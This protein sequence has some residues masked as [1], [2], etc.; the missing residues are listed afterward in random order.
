MTVCQ[1]DSVTKICNHL[2][3]FSEVFLQRQ[4]TDHQL[5][6]QKVRQRI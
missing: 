3:L 2:Q 4:K 6:H 1:K 5:L